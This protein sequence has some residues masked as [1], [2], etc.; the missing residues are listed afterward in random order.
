MKTV[1]GN[2][3]YRLF[4]LLNKRRKKQIYFLLL[5]IILNGIFESLSIVT[6]IPFLS[7]ITSNGNE[8]EL[9][10]ISQYIPQNLLNNT[11]IFL[12]ITTL[13][14]VFLFFSTIIRVF[15]NWYILR[16]TAKI[17]IDIGN[18]I[19]KKNIYQTYKEYTNKSSAKIISFIIS[20]S[21]LI[22][23]SLNY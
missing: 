7:L 1:K 4:L 9:K 12:L 13:F 8:L 2:K 16:L 10:N 19:F 3:L 5:L 21:V 23:L 22:S 11:D 15:N 18:L 14:C 20:R 6:I 17:D